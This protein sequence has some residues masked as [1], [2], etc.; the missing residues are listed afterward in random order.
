MA[1]FHDGPPADVATRPAS[2]QTVSRHRLFP[3]LQV[4]LREG[5]AELGWVVSLARAGRD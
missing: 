3:P 2:P 4:T 5:G 1:I